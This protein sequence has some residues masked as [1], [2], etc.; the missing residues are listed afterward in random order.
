MKNIFAELFA[1]KKKTQ[2][3]AQQ[4]KDVSA[5]LRSMVLGLSPAEIGIT[6]NSFPHQV[7][8][9]VMETGMR[10]G[11]YTLAV[12]ADGTASLYFSN[13][14]GIIGSGEKLEVRQVSQQ[15]IGSAN[16]FV[17]SSKPAASLE[18]PSQG[19]TEFFF[20]T[21]Q[22]VQTYAA[23]E[24]ELGEK[25]DSLAPLFHAGHAVIAAVR[26]SQSKV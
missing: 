4:P 1:K 20:L 6:P 16:R 19:N 8:G 26:Q 5:G 3:A 23:P 10:D 25:R 12:L 18:P 2:D 24:V 11:Y 21:F 14:G 17:G 7:W 13:G 22:G 15:F 9:I